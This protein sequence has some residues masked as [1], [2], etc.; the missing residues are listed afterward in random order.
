M[1][2][3]LFVLS[4]GLLSFIAI[5][6]TI[7]IADVTTQEGNPLTFNISLDQPSNVDTVIDIVT[8]GFTAY[9]LEDYIDLYT[10]VTIP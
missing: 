10:T 5:G 3:V 7:S 6:Q 9:A 8:S 4:L 2:K 1:K